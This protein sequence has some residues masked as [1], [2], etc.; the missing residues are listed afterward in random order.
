VLAV[1][2]DGASISTDRGRSWRPF[3]AVGFHSIARGRD[4]AVFACGNGGRVARLVTGARAG[5][6]GS[7]LR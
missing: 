6:G 2:A 7:L 3:G 4:G 5:C 1:G